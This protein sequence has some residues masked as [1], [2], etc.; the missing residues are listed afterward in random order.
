[1]PLMD[2]YVILILHGVQHYKGI[3]H[4]NLK[5]CVFLEMVHL[6]SIDSEISCKF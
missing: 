2:G 1:M 5:F 3:G 6:G 4:K